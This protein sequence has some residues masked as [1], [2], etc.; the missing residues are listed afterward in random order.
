MVGAH[1]PDKAII[2]TAEK[3]AVAEAARLL[4]LRQNHSLTLTLVPPQSNARRAAA[5]PTACVVQTLAMAAQARAP[6][7]A[8]ALAQAPAAARA[9]AGAAVVAVRVP[10][11]QLQ[12]LRMRGAEVFS[13]QRILFDWSCDRLEALFVEKMFRTTN[14]KRAKAP[15]SEKT[16]SSNRTI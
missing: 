9:R 8:P 10:N 15:G 3:A 16:V 1:M 2:A 12:R 4:A 5:C 7:P 14:S 11:R 6:A 13:S